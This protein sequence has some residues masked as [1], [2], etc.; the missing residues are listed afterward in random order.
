MEKSNLRMLI[1]DDEKDICN[2]LG[3]YFR[4]K[5]FKVRA[6]FSGEQAIDSIRD[7]PP[8]VLLLDIMLPGV[9]GIEVLRKVKELHPRTRVVMVTGLAQREIE[10]E[11]RIHGAAGYVRKPFGFD[12]HTWQDV[13]HPPIVKRPYD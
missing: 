11:A 10:Q 6:A 4:E 12:A 3:D 1:V 2:V 9:T 7:V 5:G 8:D 13:F